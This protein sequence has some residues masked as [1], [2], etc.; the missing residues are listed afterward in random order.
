V[1]GRTATARVALVT[2]ANRGLGLEVCR[3]LGGLGHR[4]VLTARRAAEAQ[5][6]AALLEREKLDVRPEGLD[7]RDRASVASC[8]ARLA[9]SRIRVDV[10]VNN[11]AVYRPSGVLDRS[12]AALLE[13]IDTDFLG[14]LWT[15][16]AFVPAMVRAGFGRVVNVSSDCGSF[17]F[18][19]PGPSGYAIAKAALNALTV[20][21][22]QEVRGDVLVNAAHPGWVRTRMGGPASFRSPEA[23]TP[24]RAAA[25]IVWLATLPR[26]GPHG[27]FF[28]DRKPMPW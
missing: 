22:A 2:G 15:C 25:G 28:R 14:A 23:R 9:R 27:K 26:D 3:Q 16:R 19:L 7:V 24:E 12:D 5:A 21:L 1:S 13:A 18:G 8:A 6:A 11:A 20:K 17:G 4:I 10:L